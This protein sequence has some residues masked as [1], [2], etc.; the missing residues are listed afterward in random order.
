VLAGDVYSRPAII[1]RSHNLH[2]RDIR[3]AMG[4]IASY[5]EKD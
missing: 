3:G 1:I 4:K 2:V 5:H